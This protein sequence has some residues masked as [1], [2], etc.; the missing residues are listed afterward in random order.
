[1][2]LTPIEKSFIYVSRVLAEITAAGGK[3]IRDV[4]YEIGVDVSGGLMFTA[5]KTIPNEILR[6]AE[7]KFD[8]VRWSRFDDTWVL[9]VLKD[10][11]L[12]LGSQMVKIS[13]PVTKQ[14]EV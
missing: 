4:R 7:K 10:T 12:K 1:M 13:D 14:E 2:I 11:L 9:I 6:L 3:H 8:S 5:D